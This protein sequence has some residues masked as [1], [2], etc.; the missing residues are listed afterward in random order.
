VNPRT[1]ATFELV[2]AAVAA[3]G[4]VACWLAAGSSEVVAPI[5]PTEPAKSSM[6]YS[7]TLIALAFLLAIVAGVLVVVG[8]ARLRRK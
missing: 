4:T 2:V 8:V 1:R 3:I 6:V 7:P 5:L